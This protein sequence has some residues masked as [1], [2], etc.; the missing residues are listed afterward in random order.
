MKHNISEAARIVKKSRSTIHR[1]IKQGKL[2]KEE[3]EDGMPVVDTS[4]LHRVYG[5]IHM[6]QDSDGEAKLHNATPH[7]TPPD[8]PSNNVVREEV[9]ALR[10]EKIDRLEAA[11]EAARKDVIDARKERDDWKAQAQ[12][13]LTDQRQTNAHDEKG[14]FLKRLFGAI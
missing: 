9:E 12:N 11:L 6:Q 7:E 10:K 13:L 1:H 14:S 2:S 8:T 4:E 5:M 3:D